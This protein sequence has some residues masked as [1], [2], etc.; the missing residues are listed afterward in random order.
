MWA[1]SRPPRPRVA[2][3]AGLLLLILGSVV[4]HAQS[5]G[6]EWSLAIPS[7]EAGP[8]SFA[9]LAIHAQNHSASPETLRLHIDAGALRCLGGT[10]V[11]LEVQ[12][13]EE[14]TLLHTLYVSPGAPGGSEVRISAHSDDGTEHSVPLRITTSANGKATIDGSET[15]FVHPGEK[16]QYKF[17]IIN[18]GNVPLH[19]A[20][21]PTVSPASARAIVAAENLLV[22][23]GESADGTIEVQTGYGVADVTSFVTAAEIDIAELS[24]DSARQFLYFH[25]EAFPLPAPADRAQLFET[26]KGS[27]TAGIGG[28]GSNGRRGRGADVVGYEQLTLEGLMAEN[29]RLQL[30]QA[31]VHPSQGNGIQS[32]ALSALPDM[33]GRNFFHLGLYNPYFD[34]EAGEVATAPP[35]LLST[36]ETGDGARVAVR[37]MGKDNLQIE[38]FAEQ[39]SLTLTRKD[40]FGATVSGSVQDSPLEFWRVGILSK[41]GDIGPQGRD[42]DAFGLDTGWKIPVVIPLRA[43][44]SVAAGENSG[45]GS[46]VA[47]LAGLH[48]NRTRPG[49]NDDSPLKAGVELA[50]GDKGFPGAQNGRDDQRAYASFRFSANPTYLEAYADYNNS[51]YNVVPTLEKTLAEEEDVRP[52]FL[53]TSQSRRIDAGLRWKNA[54]A[55]G[56]HLPS[57]SAEVEETSYFNKSDFF[58]KTT[59]RALAINLAPFDQPKATDWNLNLLLRGGTETHE[60]DTEGRSDSRFV[61]LGT[62]VNFSRPAPQI[63][64]KLGGPGQV[65]AEF[66]AR[67]TQNFDDDKQALN[68]TG[69]SVTAAAGWRAETW[70]ARAGVTFYDYVNQEFSDRVWVDVSRR[71]AKDWWAG[72]EAAQTHRGGGSVI[73]E[74]ANETAILL[75]FRHDFE[76]PVPWLPRHGQVTGQIFDDAN[77]NGR[78]DAGETGIE[79]VEVAVGSNKALTGPDGQFTFAPMAGGTYPVVVNSP[80][81]VHYDQSTNHP[82]EKAVLSNGAIT[83]LAIGMAKPTA[84]EG[85]IRLVRERSEADIADEPPLDLSGVEIIATDPAG[86]TQRGTVRADGFFAINLAPGA[87]E[88]AV[89]PATLKPQQNVAPAKLALKVERTRIENLDFTITERTKQIRK[90]F[91]ARNP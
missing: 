7:A 54:N 68:R 17:K 60:S 2:P 59:E 80:D 23:V 48:Y 81:D 8:R 82:T 58:D 65:N 85:T 20:I 1:H 36:R 4:L 39:N 57:G 77:N 51:K 76:I 9:A 64:E 25:T 33:S 83:Q 89:D 50:S 14:K 30:T 22:P 26:L 28:G 38:A 42:W 88:L 71:I 37:P 24:G 31:F 73:G 74:P 40:V 19:C 35:R 11:A 16:A 45:G 47:W 90:T 32:S 69:V 46:G 66:S 72:I 55:G 61:T 29:T 67:Y 84:C 6:I 70:R 15:R 63:L 21:K 78:Q 56:W 10:D 87:Y 49:E 5:S 13:N 41:R 86:R 3:V 52:D 27:V 44:F 91:S 62:D 53:L 75:T 18:T 43:E 12:P 34:L 79:G